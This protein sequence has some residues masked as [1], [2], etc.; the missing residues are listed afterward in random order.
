MDLILYLNGEE[1][2]LTLKTVAPDNNISLIVLPPEHHNEQILEYAKE[3][4]IEVKYR[5]KG[6]ALELNYPEMTII[7]SAFPYK[8]YKAETLSVKQAVNFHAA[9]LPTYR[10]RHGNV[11]AMIN[12]EKKLGVTAHEIDDK[13]DNGKILKIEEFD[14]NDEMSLSDI[15]ISLQKALVDLLKAF[16]QSNGN[17]AFED[18]KRKNIYWR[19]RTLSDGNINWLQTNRN[20]F[21]FIR[22]LSR[23]PIYAYSKYGKSTFKF[24]SVETSSKKFHSLPGSV[25][26]SNN[27][28]YVATG[29]GKSIKIIKHTT[30]HSLLTDRMVLH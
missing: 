13:F 6:T 11:W 28:L 19:A 15:Q 25:H 10:G 9:I 7:S 29:D 5:D 22:A 12:D 1:G 20:V 16:I 27:I 23:D 17:M 30:N 14:V 8:I 2:F 24:I 21:L 3:Q 4:N 26:N 18:K